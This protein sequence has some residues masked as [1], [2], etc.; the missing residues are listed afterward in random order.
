[1]P[2]PIGSG[3][4]QLI[5]ENQFSRFFN[6]VLVTDSQCNF[7]VVDGK[8]SV[9]SEFSFLKDGSPK[10]IAGWGVFSHKEANAGQRIF[11]AMTAKNGDRWVT[12]TRR[13]ARADVAAHLKS[14][15]LINSGFS[16]SVSFEN[17]VDGEYTLSIIIE[18][19]GKY[20]ICGST[21]KI[22]LLKKA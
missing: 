3:Q 11:L 15:E 1:M 19:D 10:V 21:K 12:A 16:T 7:D 5:V 4:S 22:S 13:G 18:N 8:E 14:R 17:L 9:V 20:S 2:I 6:A